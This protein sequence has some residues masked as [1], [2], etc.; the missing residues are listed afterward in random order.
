MAKIKKLLFLF[1]TL[2]FLQIHSYDDNIIYFMLENYEELETYGVNW[3]SFIVTVTRNGREVYS[4]S[5]TKSTNIRSSDLDHS[6]YNSLPVY[7]FDTNRQLRNDLP[8]ANYW[9]NGFYSNN[10]EYDFYFMIEPY[11]GSAS[12][13]NLWLSSSRNWLSTDR[14]LPVHFCNPVHMYY[15]VPEPKTWS[16]IVI[17]LCILLLKRPKRKV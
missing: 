12:G 4:G 11:E 2:L 14:R 6:S 9:R 5:V 17:G 1:F 16:L 3:D 10:P 15:N 13:D 8:D 7:Q